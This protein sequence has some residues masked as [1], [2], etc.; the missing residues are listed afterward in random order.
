VVP[1]YN[2]QVSTG[3]IIEGQGTASVK[4]D[5]TGFGGHS[6]TASVTI[7]GFDSACARTAS[8][9]LI[10]ERWDLSPKKFGSYGAFPPKEE[11]SRLN[12]FA[13]ELKN[14]PGAEAYLLAYGGR[15]GHAGEALEL[16]TRSKEYLVESRGIDA[17]RIVTLDAGYR[18]KLTIDLWIV[19]TGHARPVATPTV[20]PSEVKIIP[21]AKRKRSKH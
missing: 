20:D 8:C 11:G 10:I 3:R 12:A 19:P 9:S 18:E 2:W 5:M 13:V 14:Q 7:S 6:P 21:I 1:V 4:L 16:A 15:R 17:R